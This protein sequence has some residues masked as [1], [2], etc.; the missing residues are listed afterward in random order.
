VTAAV[1]SRKD[2]QDD[3]DA[4]WPSDEERQRLERILGPYYRATLNAIN[5]ILAR[6]LPP[7]ANS[8]VV[9]D[10]AVVRIL[11]EAATRV[12]RI[13]ETTRAAVRAQ[14]Q[15]GQLRGYSTWQ[16]AHG[17]PADGY[18]GIDGLFQ[19]TWAGRADTVARTELQHASVVASHDRFVASGVVDRVKIVDGDEWDQTCARRNGTVVPLE[20]APSLAHPNCTLVLIPVLREDIGA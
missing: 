16:I 6:L 7:D 20:Q 18:R 9:S 11:A 13:D 2:T 14:L 19:E 12:V 3:L 4:L 5:A 8:M 1:L 17:V 15:L 10:A